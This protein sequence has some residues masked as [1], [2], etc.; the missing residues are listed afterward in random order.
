M[1]NEY[2]SRGKNNFEG[3]KG[4]TVFEAQ[5]AKTVA[6][7]DEFRENMGVAKG[8]EVRRPCW[9]LY[10]I[11]K[12]LSLLFWVKN[13]GIGKFWAEDRHNSTYHLIVS[14]WL[15]FLRLDLVRGRGRRSPKKDHSAEYWSNLH[16]KEE[17]FGKGLL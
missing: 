11:D 9:A 7:E 1:G 12:D 16:K 17:E 8:R 5:W 2:S 3:E 10:S 6:S 14:C 13:K 15:L 4:T